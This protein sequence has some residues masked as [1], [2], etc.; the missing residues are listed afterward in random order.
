MKRGVPEPAKENPLDTPRLLPRRHS[1][2]TSTPHNYP[3]VTTR[4]P[5]GSSDTETSSNHDATTRGQKRKARG[6]RRGKKKQPR[7]SAHINPWT[8]NSSQRRQQSQNTTTV[9]TPPNHTASTGSSYSEAATVDN[10]HSSLPVDYRHSR[11]CVFLTISEKTSLYLLYRR[12]VDRAC[13]C[14]PWHKLQPTS[15]GG[16]HGCLQRLCT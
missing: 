13:S 4:T 8:I 15:I 9:A 3:S 6:Q 14:T 11:D 12:T 5:Q 7:L 10:L 2:T 16:C 1:E